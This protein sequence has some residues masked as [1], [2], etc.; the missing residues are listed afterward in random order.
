MNI[1]SKIAAT[2]VHLSQIQQQALTESPSRARSSTSIFTTS[3]SLPPSLT[4]ASIGQTAINDQIQVSTS[5]PIEY[6]LKRQAI[7]CLVA[8]VR[9]LVEWSQ[10]GVTAAKASLEAPL[11]DTG[12]EEDTSNTSRFASNTVSPRAHTPAPEQQPQG[13]RK[14]SESTKTNG[15]SAIDDPGQFEREKSRKTALLD[16]VKKFNWKPKKV[17]LSSTSNLKA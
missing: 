13:Q 4:T 7:E 6:H 14:V 10:Q 5:I 17:F 8:V 2:P 16:G 11:S 1:L 15:I 3:S 12:G 9:S